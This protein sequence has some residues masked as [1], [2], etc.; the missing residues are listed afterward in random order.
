MTTLKNICTVSRK[1]KPPPSSRGLPPKIP[2]NW[3][4]VTLEVVLYCPVLVRFY[5]QEI[6]EGQ[7]MNFT[8]VLLYLV[9]I[10]NDYISQP[11]KIKQITLS[12]LMIVRGAE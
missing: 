5:F 8:Y 4:P 6:L 2:E 10:L 12:A 3:G 7:N 11:T 1:D 9:Y